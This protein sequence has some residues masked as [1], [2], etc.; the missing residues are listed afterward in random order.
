MFQVLKHCLW[1]YI[2]SFYFSISNRINLFWQS[3]S[4]KQAGFC[5]NVNKQLVPHINLVNISI[6]FIFSL[7]FGTF[8][9]LT[10]PSQHFLQ[11]GSITP[12]ILLRKQ[13]HRKCEQLS[14]DTQLWMAWLGCKPR[15]PRSQVNPLRHHAR[16]DL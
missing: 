1:K 15:R 11:V 16:L 14:T 2:F 7:F 8:K 10:Q 3:L 6:A 5:R 9:Q 12:F 4:Y 13:T